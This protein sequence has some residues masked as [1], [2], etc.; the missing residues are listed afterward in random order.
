VR[1]LAFVIAIVNYALP[2]PGLIAEET[3][4]R[5]PEGFEVSLFAG[6]ELAHDIYSMTIDASGRVVVAGAGYV[7][8]LHDDNAD[9]RADRASLFSSLPA[10]GAHGMCFDGNDLI[11]TGDNSLLRLRDTNGDGIAD[12]EPQVLTNLRNPEHGANGVVQGPDGWFYVICGNDAGVSEKHVT[13]ASSP[14]KHP[15]CGAVIRVSPDGKQSEVVAHGFRN[16]YDLAFGPDG[17]LFTVDAD[18]ERDQHLPWYTPTRLFDI[19]QGMHHGWMLQGW[20]KSWNRPSWFPDNVERLA[21]IGR[22]SPTGVIVYRH[23]QFPERYRGSVFSCCWTLGRIYHFP[24]ERQGSTFRTEKEI[25]LETTGDV[26]FAPVDLAVGPSGDLFVAIGGRRTRGSVFRVRHTE[27]SRTTQWN[28]DLLWSKS[29]THRVKQVLSADEPLSAWSR[30]HWVPAARQ[31]GGIPFLRAARDQTLSVKER[32]R[33]IEILTELY[34][35]TKFLAAEVTP[36]GMAGIIAPQNFNPAADNA[37]RDP[38]VMARI[39]WS[40]SRRDPTPEA[41]NALFV[42]SSWPDQRQPNVIVQ[43]AAWDALTAIPPLPVPNA[44]S[45]PAGFGVSYP[46]GSWQDSP[47]HRVQFSRLLADAIHRPNIAEQSG[48]NGLWQLHFRDKLEPT[49]ASQAARLFN[50]A[51]TTTDVLEAIRLIELAFGDIETSDA[52]P[53]ILPGYALHGDLKPHRD[54]IKQ[55]S[56]PLIAQFPDEDRAVNLEL[57]RLCGM[58]GVDDPRLPQ[59]LARQCTADSPVADDVH[60]LMVLALLETPRDEPTTARTAEALVRLAGKMERGRLY[61]SRNWPLRVGEMFERLCNRDSQFAAAVYGHPQFGHPQHSLFVKHMPPMHRSAAAKRLIDAIQS[62]DAEWTPELVEVVALLPPAEAF[63]LLRPQWDSFTTRDAVTQVL[64]GQPDLADRER[65]VAALSSAQPSIVEAATGALLKLK[66]QPTEAE[67]L[68]LMKTLRRYISAPQ[69]ESVRRSLAELLSQWS[70]GKAPQESAADKDP[71]VAYQPYFDW[72][73]QAHRPLAEKLTGWSDDAA[74]WRERLTNVDWAKGDIQRGRS[75]F[76]KR[77][78]H[79]CHAG[80]G[81]LGPDLAGVAGRFSRDDLFAHIIDP[82]KEVSPLYQTTQ[83][84]TGGGRVVVGLIVYESPEST[85]VQTSPDTTVRIAGEEITSMTKS[86]QSLMPVGLLNDSAPEELADL[87]AYM[88]TLS[89]AGVR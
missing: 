70:G 80:T 67:W 89:R 2:Q 36:A 73:S 12:G 82:N 26:G 46:F 76:E 24:L 61:P 14:V 37:I 15:Q 19:A 56:G 65:F 29:A 87:Y 53:K 45:M 10:S 30:T 47:D 35:T 11:C 42:L 20:Q 85:L 77:A 81:P 49:R 54:L 78:C 21:E 60:Y 32:V 22:G 18:G 75:V 1:R 83:V 5:A 48:R 9:G 44:R 71:R 13:T 66:V 72:F 23:R 27:G 7:K 28:Y 79:R 41:L 38:L 57:A 68:A 63:P 39:A 55:L 64:A 8:I 59:R 3:G 4:L 17:N 43:R 16:P 74:A 33:A 6:D 88:Q 69:N 51:A 58:L 31:L 86:N 62:S 84:V 25:F 52:D 34:I 40:L 50:T